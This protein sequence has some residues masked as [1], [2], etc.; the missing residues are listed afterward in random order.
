MSFTIQSAQT[1]YFIISN[2]ED[3]DGSVVATVPKTEYNP[4]TDVR[5]LVHVLDLFTMAAW[6]I[7]T[8]EPPIISGPAPTIGFVQSSKVPGLYVGYKSVGSSSAPLTELRL[9]RVLG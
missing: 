5:I 8:I 4:I 6:Q 9:T 7:V 1:E 2:G 3:S